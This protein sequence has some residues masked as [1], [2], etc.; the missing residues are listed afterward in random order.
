MKMQEARRIINGVPKGFRVSFDH[1]RGSILESDHFP[2]RDEP[3]IPSEAEA[4]TLA[5]MFAENTKGKC[6]NIYVVNEE[7]TPV[8][9]YELREIENR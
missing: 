6:I 9:G 8:K 1:K 5:A 7:W 2:D 4:W 3:L